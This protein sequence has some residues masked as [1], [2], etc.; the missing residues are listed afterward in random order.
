MPLQQRILLLSLH[1]LA[2]IFLLFYLVKFSIFPRCSW[3]W[4]SKWALQ[5]MTRQA[6]SEDTNN[7]RMYYVRICT[8][9]IC[10]YVLLCWFQPFVRFLWFWKYEKSTLAPNSSFRKVDQKVLLSTDCFLQKKYDGLLTF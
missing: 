1:S 2:Q 4:F 7:A 9:N 8:Y 10:F 5:S 6:C 3:A